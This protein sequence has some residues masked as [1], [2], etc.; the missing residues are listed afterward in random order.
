ML[1]LSPFYRRVSWG[2]ALGAAAP[3]VT[4]GAQK[5]KEK[6]KGKKRE[7]KKKEKKGGD[8]KGEKIVNGTNG[9][10]PFFQR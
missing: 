9:G 6:G 8:I 5:K 10:P 3:R 7:K 4:K 2:G 1:L